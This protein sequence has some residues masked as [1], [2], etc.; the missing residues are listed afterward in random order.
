MGFEVGLEG[1]VGGEGSSNPDDAGIFGVDSTAEHCLD[2]VAPPV[3][4]V[5]VSVQ[6]A[7]CRS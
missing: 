6:P 5:V 2:E 4:F 7:Y 1:L 3:S